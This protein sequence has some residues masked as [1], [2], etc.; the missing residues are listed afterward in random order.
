MDP[1][2]LLKKTLIILWKYFLKP[3]LQGFCSPIKKFWNKLMR[4]L[5]KI[6]FF[7]LI[8]W[9][10]AQQNNISNLIIVI[11]PIVILYIIFNKGIKKIKKIFK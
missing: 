2:V 3:I 5:G 1:K 10:L 9:I 7:L 4:F 8:L 6:G 11:I